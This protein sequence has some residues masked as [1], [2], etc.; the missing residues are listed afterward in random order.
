MTEENREHLMQNIACDHY[1]ILLIYF[2]V[3]LLM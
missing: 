3:S 1:D 2:I